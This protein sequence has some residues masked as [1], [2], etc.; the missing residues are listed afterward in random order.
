MLFQ[1]KAVPV[2]LI[3]ASLTSRF[4][5]NSGPTRISDDGETGVNGIGKEV[6]HE[7]VAV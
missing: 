2:M 7:T 4:S 1:N 5:K 6:E 3:G